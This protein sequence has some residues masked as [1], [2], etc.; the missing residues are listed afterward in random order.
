MPD[1]LVPVAPKPAEPEIVPEAAITLAGAARV[2]S[3]SERE[4]SKLIKKDLLQADRVG[5]ITLV[6]LA[7]IDR[8]LGLR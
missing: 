4:I 6:R 7:S 1:A 5:N 8:L 3:V 2:L